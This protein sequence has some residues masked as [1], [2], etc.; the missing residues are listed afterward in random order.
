MSHH[1]GYVAILFAALLFGISTTF[2]K[3]LLE[4]VSPL[5]IAS[6]T[7]IVA[8][9]FLGAINFLPHKAKLTSLLKLPGN[10]RKEVSLVFWG[11][12]LIA[13][14]NVPATM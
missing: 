9:T 13:P 2:N 6:V 8:G 3:I 5:I 10:L 7:Y 14:R 1:W 4:E 11:R 12:K